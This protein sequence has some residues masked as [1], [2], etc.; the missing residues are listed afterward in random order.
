MKKAVWCL[1]LLFTFTLPL[2]AFGQDSVSV[3][4]KQYVAKEQVDKA[5]E[6]QD[7][8]KK[9]VIIKKRVLDEERVSNS[10]LI[11]QSIPAESGTI[12][13]YNTK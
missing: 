3:P 8:A 11:Q 1:V 10:N 5:K 9:D 6:T 7:K 13:V 2:V 4:V 12:K